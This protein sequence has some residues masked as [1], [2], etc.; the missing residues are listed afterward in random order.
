LFGVRRPSPVR[1]A[2]ADTAGDD[3]L[4]DQ[5]LAEETR[6]RAALANTPPVWRNAET[7]PIAQLR[8]RKHQRNGK[9]G[10]QD[11]IIIASTIIVAS[12]TR[13]D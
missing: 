5:T 1:A 10:Q 2:P 12:T 3:P 9:R 7:A 13:A 6:P 8:G 4:A 11:R